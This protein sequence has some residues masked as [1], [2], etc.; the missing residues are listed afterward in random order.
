LYDADGALLYIGISYYPEDRIRVHLSERT[1]GA[2]VDMSK[3]RIEWFGTRPEARASEI[4]AI[5]D[6]QPRHNVAETPLHRRVSGFKSYLTAEELERWH[7][8]DTI[9]GRQSAERVAAGR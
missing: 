7:A 6:E 2:D 9:S 1:W 8:T 4:K 3:T 5:H